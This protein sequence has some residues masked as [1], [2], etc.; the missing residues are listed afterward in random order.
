MLDSISIHSYVDA[1]VESAS[2]TLIAV[3]F[4][5]QTVSFRFS[6]ANILTISP[7][8]SLKKARKKS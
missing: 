3:S 2:A 7:N 4:V 1:T 8:G 6:L 5:H